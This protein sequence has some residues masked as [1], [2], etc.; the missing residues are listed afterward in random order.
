MN[1]YIITNHED[2]KHFFSS[3]DPFDFILELPETIY[4]TG[5]SSLAL[6]DHNITVDFIGELYV[7]CDIIQNSLVNG[8]QLP[9]LRIIK[10]KRD[11][12]FT[13]PYFI[14]LNI[15]HFKRIRFYI[16]M[17]DG[18]VP[19]FNIKLLNLSLLLRYDK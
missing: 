8:D 9:L 4:S 3:N 19:S 6:L 5:N 14:K 7:Y 11:N 2:S 17:G 13:F 10:N 18:G 1:R 12:S 15:D 16:R